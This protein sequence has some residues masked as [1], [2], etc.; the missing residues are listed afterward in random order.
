MRMQNLTT[1]FIIFIYMYWPMRV[2]VVSQRIFYN[3]TCFFRTMTQALSR[4]QLNKHSFQL[5]LHQAPTCR[6]TVV[7]GLCKRHIVKHRPVVLSLH[8]A[9]QPLWQLL[10]SHSQS[11]HSLARKNKHSGHGPQQWSD[12]AT[13]GPSLLYQQVQS[14]PIG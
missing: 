7:E 2:R 5:D 8:Q 12:S 1:L 9:P 13:F 6:V 14:R 11:N 10:L 3:L 4:R